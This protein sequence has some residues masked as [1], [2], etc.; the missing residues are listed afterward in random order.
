MRQIFGGRPDRRHP[1]VNCALYSLIPSIGGCLCC[2]RLVIELEHASVDAAIWKRIPFRVSL[3]NAAALD[4]TRG[5]RD[6]EVVAWLVDTVRDAGDF[7]FCLERNGGLVGVKEAAVCSLEDQV[8]F[9]LHFVREAGGGG[10]GWLWRLGLRG[11]PSVTVWKNRIFIFLH[12]L[13]VQHLLWRSGR[14]SLWARHWRL[15]VSMIYYLIN[16]I[17]IFKRILLEAQKLLNQT[18]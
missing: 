4:L 1:R 11:L 8:R 14:C 2:G 13:K 9:C 18:T 12:F 16:G 6:S 7:R 3:A 15:I 10:G 17:W 5:W